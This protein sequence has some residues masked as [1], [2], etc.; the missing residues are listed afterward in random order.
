MPFFTQHVTHQRSV[1]T[2]TFPI[3][4]KHPN[5]LLTAVAKASRNSWKC[6]AWLVIKIPPFMA[7]LNHD[8]ES[9]KYPARLYMLHVRSHNGP[10]Q[11][12]HLKWLLHVSW[13]GTAIIIIVTSDNKSWLWVKTGT[14]KLNFV[15]AKMTHRDKEWHQQLELC[16][17]LSRCLPKGCQSNYNSTKNR[18]RKTRNLLQFLCPSLLCLFL[19]SGFI[20]CTNILIYLFLVSTTGFKCHKKCDGTH[21]IYQQMNL[22]LQL[23]S[24]CFLG[25]LKKNSE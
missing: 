14:K 6:S 17:L 24:E 2:A 3:T 23:C 21:N 20:T 9:Q 22:C 11:W 18:C 8:S 10:K 19:F 5:S 7:I 16:S 25:K 1:A 15:P 4:S 12:C 13:I